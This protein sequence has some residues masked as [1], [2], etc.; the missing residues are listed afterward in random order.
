MNSTFTKKRLDLT[1]TLGTGEFGATEGD[2]VTLSGLRMMADIVFAGGETMGALQLR[3]FGLTQAMMNKLTT[4]GPVA[5]AIRSKNKVLLA[6]GDDVNGM[7]IVYQGTIDQAWADYSSAPDVVFNVI[8][9]AGLDAAVKPVNAISFKGSADVAT[10]MEG[11]AKTMGVAFENRGV[12]AKL[13][14]PYFPGT[15]LMQVKSCARAAN[16]WYTIDRDALIIWPKKGGEPGVIPL[17]SPETGLV[18]Y[19]AFSSKGMSFSTMFNQDIRLPGKVLVKSSIPMACGMFNVFNV[20]HSLSSEIAGGPWFST[21][22]CY[23]DV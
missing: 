8:A 5:T 15:A 20:S 7:H 6:A 9:Y 18:G 1:I 17:I 2:T 12:S 11:L 23:P 10:I 16:I 13:S 3:V 22:E 19:P 21:V 14:N 4:I